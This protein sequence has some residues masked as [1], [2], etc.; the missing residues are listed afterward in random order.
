M[1]IEHQNLVDSTEDA[2]VEVEAQKLDNAIHVLCV[3]QCYTVC[4]DV[5]INIPGWPTTTTMVIA[6]LTMVMDSSSMSQQLQIS[7]NTI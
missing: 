5:R 2:A 6:I 7:H 1:T 3:A 4:I